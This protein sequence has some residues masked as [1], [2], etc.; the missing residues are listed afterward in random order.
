[1]PRLE[2]AFATPAKRE[3]RTH[4]AGK[5]DLRERL[6]RLFEA[7]L[8]ADE[9]CAGR[10]GSLRIH[11]D[12]PQNNLQIKILHRLAGGSED[13]ALWRGVGLL[14]RKQGCAGGGGMA[15]GGKGLRKKYFVATAIIQTKSNKVMVPVPNP[16]LGVMFHWLGGLA[17]ASFYCACA[18]YRHALARVAGAHR[19]AARGLHD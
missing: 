2:A 14:L 16:L 9:A 15:G 5:P 18:R 1:M 8:D 4:D 12:D 11:I 17:S 10:T 13:A 6:Q 7:G 3:G 19:G